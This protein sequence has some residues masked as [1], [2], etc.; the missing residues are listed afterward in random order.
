MHSGPSVT[1]PSPRARQGTM[2][3]VSSGAQ[4][5]YMIPSPG[6]SPRPLTSAGYGQ[7][8]RTGVSGMRP[9]PSAYTGASSG[10]IPGSRAP[11]AS[12]SVPI[13]SS[14]IMPPRRGA[15][16][17]HYSTPA[18]PPSITGPSPGAH[19]N[20]AAYGAQQQPVLPRMQMASRSAPLTPVAQASMSRSPSHLAGP[21]TCPSTAFPQGGMRSPY[22]P[23]GSRTPSAYPLT[24]SASTAQCIQLPGGSGPN[25]SGGGTGHAPGIARPSTARLHPYRPAGGQPPRPWQ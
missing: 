14:G 19:R 17:V 24:R 21:M 23:Q 13:A 5:S 20:F 8:P 6:L 25:R 16:V 10:G 9:P 1:A 11:F 3:P 4:I 2:P 12:P 18:M 22:P 15:P 7:R